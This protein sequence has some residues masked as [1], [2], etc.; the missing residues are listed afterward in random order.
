M[1][2]INQWIGQFGDEYT[3]RNDFD[4]KT[5]L[6]A[7]REIIPED[8]NYLLEVGCNRGNNLSSLYP[9]EP[10]GLG[11]VA[12]GLEPNTHAIE[13]SGWPAIDRRIIQGHA[14]NIPF[15]DNSF[16]LVF[17]CGVLMHIPDYEQAMKEI[18]RVTKKYALAIEYRG[19]GEEVDYRGNKGMLWK[20]KGYNYPGTLLKEGD[21]GKEFDH[22]HYWLYQKT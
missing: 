6:P 14:Q 3:D 22:C 21:L 9:S 10:H 2:P 12:I 7:F 20:R 18:W 11:K 15:A 17:T 19:E 4:P 5:R 13:L 8:V 16:D 1:E